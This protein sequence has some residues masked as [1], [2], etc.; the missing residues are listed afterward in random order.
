MTKALEDFLNEIEKHV[1]P[2][3]EK[4]LFSLGGRGYYENPASDLLAFFLKPDAE[5]GFQALFLQTFL[6]CMNV[7]SARF[8]M[9]GVTVSREDK[10]EEGS[11]PDIV[12]QC[13]DWV[14]LIENKVYHIPNN[15][16][17]SYE[18]YGRRLPGGKNLSMG[19]LSPKGIPVPKRP[20]WKPVSYPDY[21][22]A[23]R[24]RLVEEF[25]DHAYSKWMVFARE[26]I[27]HFENELYQPTMNDNDAN[28]IEQHMEQIEQAKTLASDYRVFLSQLLIDNLM[29]AIA[30][31]NFRPKEETWGIRCYADNKWGR[32]HLVF[33]PNFFLPNFSGRSP[34]F[35]VRIDLEDFTPEQKAQALQMFS[36]MKCSI[37]GRCLILQTQICF[38]NRKEAVDELCKLGGLL[39][40]L[41]RMHPNPV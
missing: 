24:R 27:L 35:H 30:G 2:R 14:L 3:K 12:V 8:G 37:E 39:A 20:Q 15:P 16:F 7:D 36:G 9:A 31:H 32:S 28:Y 10:T 17:E 11:R 18:V 40:E 25:F 23:L 34:E 33:L 26:F 41:F 4:T 38:K 6:K 19:I 29:K 22:A 5:H 1:P 21:C 13:R